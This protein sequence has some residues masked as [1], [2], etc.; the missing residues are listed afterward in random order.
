MVG[1]IS[2]N[3]WHLHLNEDR[4]DFLRYFSLLP[5]QGAEDNA[6]N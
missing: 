2:S 1:S 4:V 3:F 6:V 5:E